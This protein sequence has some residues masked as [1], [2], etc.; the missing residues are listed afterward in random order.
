MKLAVQLSSST[1]EMHIVNRDTL[2]GYTPK[3]SHC[4]GLYNKC[5]KLLDV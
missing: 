3:I 4:S 1:F 5:F 2:R